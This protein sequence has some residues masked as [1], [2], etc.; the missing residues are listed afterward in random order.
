MPGPLH[1]E[2]EAT[3]RAELATAGER[4]GWIG[5]CT[6]TQAE[7][8][9]RGV[10]AERTFMV[11]N[12]MDV[13]SF[14]PR[15]P[16][17]LRRELGVADD[18]PIIG[19][20]AYAYAPKRYLGQ[21]R[22]LKGHEDAI[23]AMVRV[24]QTHPNAL[25]VFVGGPWGHAEAYFQ[26]IVRYGKERL[27]DQVVFLGTRSDVRDMYADFNIALYPSHS[28]N[29]GGTGEGALLGVPAI[30]TRVGGHPD[31]VR[32][33]ETGWLV[34]PRQPA[35]LAVA[36]LDALARPDEAARR[37]A[38]AK[39]RAHEIFDIR[40]TVDGVEAAYDRAAMWA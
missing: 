17:T 19:M 29:L 30:A 21:T 22:G 4:D 33:G 9:R 11:Y 39:R 28:E 6:W 36:I 12:G 3:A 15:P 32:D 24:R 2:Y 5:S 18:V 7:Y 40:R 10:P 25:L 27:G 26:R 13:D 34:P 23:D 31:M 38:A 35:E 37:A 14:I 20:L 8:I 1:M 16:G